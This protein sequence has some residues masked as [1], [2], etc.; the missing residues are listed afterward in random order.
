MHSATQMPASSSSLT[1]GHEWNTGQEEGRVVIVECVQL[2]L[3]GVRISHMEYRLP[4]P[5]DKAYTMY[6][7]HTYVRLSYRV[8]LLS[9]HWTPAVV[10]VLCRQEQIMNIM[11]GEETAPLVKCVCSSTTYQELKPSIDMNTSPRALSSPLYGQPD[12]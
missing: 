12:S 2:V 11:Q 5:L 9:V 7:T 6:N 1:G 3:W 10:H 4:Y 8:P